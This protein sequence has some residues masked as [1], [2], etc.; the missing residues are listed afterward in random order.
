MSLMSSQV[1]VE[2]TTFLDNSAKSVTHGITMIAST[3]EFYNS[4]VSFTK[5][6]ADSLS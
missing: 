6:F 1:I 2:D 5:K 4:T 3:M